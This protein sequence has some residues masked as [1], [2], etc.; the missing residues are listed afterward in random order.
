MMCIMSI[1]IICRNE[2]QNKLI[3]LFAQCD[4]R[5]GCGKKYRERQKRVKRGQIDTVS[6]QNAY[7][8]ASPS[9]HPF[10]SQHMQ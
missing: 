10:D 7:F 8:A 4:A 2:A 5:L 6:C 9:P 3:P 1:P